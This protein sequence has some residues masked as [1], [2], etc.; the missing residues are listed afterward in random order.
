[1]AAALAFAATSAGAEGLEDRGSVREGAYA[2]PLKWTGPY[3]GAAA[4]Y[5]IAV[6]ELSGGGEN[7]VFDIALR[8]AQGVVTVGYDWQLSPVWVLGLF[9]DYAFGKI[10]GTFDEADDN[11][12]IDKQWA[13]GARLGLVVTPSTLLYTSAGYTRADVEVSGFFSIEETLDG[14]FAG[15]GVEQAINRN[16]SLKLDYRFSDYEDFTFQGFNFDNE[17]HSVRLGLTWRFGDRALI[18]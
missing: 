5:G 7:D 16:L 4:A 15:L 18:K 13:V 11:F 17:V 14:Y 10:E 1:M 12:I 3:L 8:G 9:G 2:A 6:S